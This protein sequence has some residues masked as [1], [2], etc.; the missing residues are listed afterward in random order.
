MIHGLCLSLLYDPWSLFTSS[1]D[2]WSLFI[3]FLWSMGF[4]YLFS[5]I[6][7]LCLP[8]LMIHGLCLSLFY[9]PRSLFIS[10]LWSM[11]FVYLFSMIHGLCLSRLMIHGLFLSLFY[12]PWSLFISFLWSMVFVY[13]F[14]M[15]HGLC[16][17]IFHERLKTI[18]FDHGLHCHVRCEESLLKKRCMT[19]RYHTMMRH[20]NYK[21][22]SFSYLVMMTAIIII[23]HYAHNHD[24]NK[25]IV[26]VNIISS[27]W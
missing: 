10:F 6:H 23:F 22:G 21:L 2:P 5:V 14:S 20:R 17:P 26:I 1:Y 8:L 25:M 27:C 9:D 15:I 3:S 16:L 4:V 13:L 11:V 18:L 7:G 19:M 12:D 24:I